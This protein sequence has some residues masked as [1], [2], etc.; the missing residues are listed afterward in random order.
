MSSATTNRSA[1]CAAYTLEMGTWHAT[2]RQCGFRVSDRVRGRAATIYR[3]HIKETNRFASVVI[4]LTEA[5]PV[6]SVDLL[7]QS[8]LRADRRAALHRRTSA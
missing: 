5:A 7:G 3:D 4:D 1:H 6:T 2:C 8:P